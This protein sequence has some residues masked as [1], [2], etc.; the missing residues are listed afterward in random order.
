MSRRRFADVLGRGL[1]NL[2]HYSD[3]PREVIDPAMHLTNRNIT[4]AERDLAN[5]AVRL[6]P[7]RVEPKEVYAPYPP[8]AY[9]GGENYK[10]AMQ[11]QAQRISYAGQAPPQNIFSPIAWAQFI[12]AWQSGA[13]KKK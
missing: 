13:Y 8:Q 1:L 2:F 6:T 12:K 3:E 5:A 7:F 9:Y 11:Q 4:G 10:I